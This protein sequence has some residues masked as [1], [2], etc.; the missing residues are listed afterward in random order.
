VSITTNPRGSESRDDMLA[1]LTQALEAIAR[2][3]SEKTR[4]TEEVFNRRPGTPL[5]RPI[6]AAALARLFLPGAPR[7]WSFGL[8]ALACVGAVVV[9]RPVSEDRAAKPITPLVVEAAKADLGVQQ[10]S[11][12][13][14]AA[15]ER[16]ALAPI[17]PELTQWGQAIARQLA[18]L[19][20]AIE[21]LKTS[22]AQLAHDNAELTERLKETQDRI[23]GRDV[24]LAETLK[25]IQGNMTRD[26]L[27]IAEQLKASQDQ[28][29]S[30]GEQIK[31]SGAPKPPRPPKATAPTPT[32]S[33]LSAIATTKPA[34]KPKPPQTAGQSPKSS[35]Q[36]QPKQP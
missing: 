27:S 32:P 33:I 25:A 17:A 9:A 18:N 16:A 28:L 19:E 10:T 35:T 30:I 15:P 13:P 2:P 21:H 6:F 7:L 22:Q 4:P 1:E 3:T 36:S 12:Q 11:V 31:A 23:A 34:P 24:E 26:N 20:Q 8:L 5:E 29:A 14:Q